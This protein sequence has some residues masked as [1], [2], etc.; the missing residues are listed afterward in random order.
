QWANQGEGRLAGRGGWRSAATS[1]QRPR[2]TLA[3]SHNPSRTLLTVLGL[4]FGL[5]VTVGN[6]IGAGILGTPGDIAARLPAV[7]LFISVWIVGAL[8]ALLGANALAEL[9]TLVPKSG[10]QC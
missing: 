6:I 5:A 4:G 10:G 1:D 9:A 2:Y 3:V 7:A 8:Y